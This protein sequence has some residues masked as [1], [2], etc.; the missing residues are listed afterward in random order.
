V[1]GDPPNSRQS[2]DA[3][4]L[5]VELK[6]APSMPLEFLTVRLVRSGERLSVEAA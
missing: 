5:I 6:V 3:G 2:L 4:R 1:V